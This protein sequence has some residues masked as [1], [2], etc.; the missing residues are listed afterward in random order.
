MYYFT[1]LIAQL[2]FLYYITH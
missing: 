1:I 2:W